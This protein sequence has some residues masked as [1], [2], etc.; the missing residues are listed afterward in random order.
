VDNQTYEKSTQN[1]YLF[2]RVTL[3]LSISNNSILWDAIVVSSA[4]IGVY[5]RRSQG[6]L[7]AGDPEA[8]N[9]FGLNLRG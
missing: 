6:V 5:R 4:L 1:V 9:C 3:H 2:P 8:K 7:G